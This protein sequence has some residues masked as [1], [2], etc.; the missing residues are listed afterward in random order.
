ML[1]P[2]KEDHA[3]LEQLL[4]ELIKF[5]NTPGHTKEEFRNSRAKIVGASRAIF[6]REWDRIKTEDA[7]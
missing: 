5:V 7:N 2:Q 3:K 4:E 6:K 1:N